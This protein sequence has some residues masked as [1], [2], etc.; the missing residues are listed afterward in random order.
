METVIE[1]VSFGSI[2]INGRTYRSD[3][4]VFPDG[5]VEDGWW[6]DNG[7]RLTEKDVRRLVADAPEVIVAGTGIYGRMRPE[8]GLAEHLSAAGIRFFHDWN[9]NAAPRFNELAASHRAAACFHLTC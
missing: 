3:V 8:K 9:K 2:T 4:L 6:R 5:R 7:H 1:G